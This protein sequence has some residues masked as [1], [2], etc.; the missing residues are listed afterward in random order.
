LEVV[1]GCSGVVEDGIARRDSVTGNGQPL[2]VR[3][4]RNEV[5]VDLGAVAGR[6][7]RA[8]RARWWSDREQSCRR[9]GIC[10]RRAIRR[11][12]CGR[13]VQRC[14]RRTRGEQEEQSSG[15]HETGRQRS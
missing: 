14:S 11:L 4:L 2:D 6:A 1:D 3:P 5:R 15:G 12:D 9:S 7:V 8:D 10:Q 13:S